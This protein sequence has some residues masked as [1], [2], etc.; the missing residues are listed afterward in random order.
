MEDI[1]I[2]TGGKSIMEETG[3]KLES[4]KL[5]DLGSAKAHHDRQR[6]HHDRGWRR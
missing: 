3:I 2:L 1:A 5:E 6:Q 4:V